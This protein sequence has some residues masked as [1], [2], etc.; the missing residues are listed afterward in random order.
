MELNEGQKK[1]VET[2]IKQFYAGKQYVVIAGRAGTGKTTCVSHIIKE[3]GVKSVCYCAYTGKACNVLAKK[4]NKPASTIHHLIYEWHYSKKAKKLIPVKKHSI[5]YSIVVVD[6]CSMIGEHLLKELLSYK[7]P[8]FIFLGDT[9][10]IPPVKE[11]RNFLLDE[12]HV[13]LTQIERQ[14]LESNIIQLSAKVCDGE[15]IPYSLISPD[16]RIYNYQELSD[17]MLSWADQIIC[18]TNNLRKQLNQHMR[19][20]QG[21][22]GG[23]KVGDK[24]ICMK[25]DWDTQDSLG[26]PI[27]NGTIGYIRK[28]KY[29]NYFTIETDYG[30]FIET[31]VDLKFFENEQ[32]PDRSVSGI[33]Y[34][35]FGYAVSAWKA[36][37]SEWGK[38]LVL[39]EKFPREELLHRQVLYTA[40]TRASDK[41]VL[42]RGVQ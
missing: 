39:E 36:Q 7:K 5:G 18:S 21:F 8:F 2:A 27:I 10:Q 6:E 40:M 19:E 24:I 30:S 3:L 42:I 23:P 12:P 17:S 4:G 1:A 11:Q 25:N 13:T 15:E 32:L 26:Y 14:N 38:V 33:Q 31:K 20:L 22:E 9:N 16:T 37:G 28:I 29:R 34:W 35:T 41:L